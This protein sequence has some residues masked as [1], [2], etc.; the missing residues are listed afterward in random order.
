MPYN[1]NGEFYNDLPSN[2]GDPSN[3]LFGMFQDA[4]QRSQNARYRSGAQA[5]IGQAN[6]IGG[7]LGDQLQRQTNLSAQGIQAKAEGDQNLLS[8]KKVGL[9]SDKFRFDTRSQGS[10]G[11]GSNSTVTPTKSSFDT[12]LENHNKLVERILN[13][14][15]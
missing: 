3:K 13:G 7:V 12:L 15:K 4:I 9:E 8:Q 6:A 5:A 10:L 2:Q 14:G 11:I 1:N